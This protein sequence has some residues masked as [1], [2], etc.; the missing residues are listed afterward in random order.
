M[1]VEDIM[2]MLEIARRDYATKTLE[3][4]RWMPREFV[5]SA[6]DRVGEF[7]ESF[8]ATSEYWHEIGFDVWA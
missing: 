3:S 1:D 8:P 6:A 7:I 2:E 5:D 4:E